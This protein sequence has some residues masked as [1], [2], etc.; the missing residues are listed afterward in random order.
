MGEDKDEGATAA[1]Y[2]VEGTNDPAEAVSDRAERAPRDLHQLR[3]SAGAVRAGGAAAGAGGRAARKRHAASPRRARRTA[4]E[5]GRQ[6]ERLVPRTLG[7]T[8][9]AVPAAAEAMVRAGPEEIEVA[10]C[11]AHMSGP[12]VAPSRLGASSARSCAG[13]RRFC[14]GAVPSPNE[15]GNADQIARAKCSS[16][17]SARSFGSIVP[18]FLTI[19]NLPLRAWAMYMF[20]RT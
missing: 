13:A 5:L 2:L 4:R 20:M 1:R 3:Q 9:W 8:R 12:D 15:G 11:G 6:L 10:V 19:S 14:P 7:A 16:S 17:L 18:R